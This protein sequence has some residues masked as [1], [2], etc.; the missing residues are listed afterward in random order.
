M[1]HSMHSEVFWVLLQYLAIEH[2]MLL[3]NLSRHTHPSVCLA[4]IAVRECGADIFRAAEP[5]ALCRSSFL[6]GSSFSL[7]LERAQT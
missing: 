7:D 3:H 1:L 4:P 6:S 2:S 5:G